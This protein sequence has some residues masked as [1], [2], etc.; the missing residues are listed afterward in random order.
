MKQILNAVNYLHKNN[1]WH[2]DIKPDNILVMKETRDGL[3]IALAD[4]GCANVFVTN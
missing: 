3:E 2:R 1:I 4:F